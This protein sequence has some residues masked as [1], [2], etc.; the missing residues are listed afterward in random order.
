MFMKKGY[1]TVV[2]LL[3][4][5]PLAAQLYVEPEQD[6]ECTVFLEKEGRGRAQQGLEI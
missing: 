6:V 5:V 4:S 2:S 3:L 1:L